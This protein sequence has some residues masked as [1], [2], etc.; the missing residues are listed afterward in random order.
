MRRYCERRADCFFLADPPATAG[1]GEVR[2]FAQGLAVR[3]S[4]AAVYFPWLLA[5]TPAPPSGFVAGV[6]ARTDAQRGVWKPPAGPEAD[7]R[8]ATGLSHALGTA[9]HETLNVLGVNTIRA[10]RGSPL[11]VWSARTLAAG[12]EWRYVSV[13]RLAIF[14]ERSIDEGTSWAVFEP[15]GEPLWSRLRLTID[16]LL[17]EQWYLGA[18]AGA[19]ADQAF[20]V[21]CDRTT[22]TQADINN[23]HAIVVVGFAPLRPAEFVTLRFSPQDRGQLISRRGSPGRAGAD[24]PGQSVPGRAGHATGGPSTVASIVEAPRAAATDTRWWPSRM[25]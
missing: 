9:D 17:T 12:T 6:Y 18:L 11:A 23:R 24:A 16:A 4:Y 22:M 1:P 5:P 13:R 20:F 8:G 14:L 2:A 15:N 25:A 7:V 10:Y 19:K 3:S 21:T